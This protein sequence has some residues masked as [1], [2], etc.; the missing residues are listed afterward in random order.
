MT[1]TFFYSIA[2]L[3]QSNTIDDLLHNMSTIEYI[4]QKDRNVAEYCLQCAE[5]GNYPSA[6]Y[7]VNIYDKPKT[8]LKT[9][10][11]IVLHFKE[12]VD[13][14][15]RQA[16][17]RNVTTAINETSTSADLLTRLSKIIT[18]TENANDSEFSFDDC[19]PE[20]YGDVDKPL[21]SGLM[22]GIEELDKTTNG[23]QRGT[24]ASICGFTGH[25]KSTACNSAAYQNIV[26]G[27][28][29][30]IISI[31][32]PPDM[33]WK[34]FETR[35]M[36]EREL[37]VDVHNM[38][39]HT[40]D[41]SVGKQVV[42]YEP[43]FKRDVVPNLLVIDES[44]I[45]KK[46][47]TD[48]RKINKL[49]KAAE[50]K[51]GGLDMVIVDHVGQLELL[52]PETG[53]IILKQL[54]SAAKTFKN[55]NGEKIVMVWAVQCNREGNRRAIRREGQYDLQAIADLN[56]VERSS[57]YCVFLYTSDAMKITQE[58]KV[59]MLKNRLGVPIPVPFVTSFTPSVV[60]VGRKF[61]RANMSD[62]DFSFTEMG[63]EYEDIPP[64]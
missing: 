27:K 31:E 15:A 1:A 17:Q 34:Q 37:A 49:F 39:H 47:M 6:D 64:F 19:K 42:S 32:L 25:G 14:H 28:K 56:E 7:F 21:D 52:Y 30:L 62:V 20:L 51:L 26:S 11:E 59:S 53:N 13:F 22:T 10:A 50:R 46:I 29:V 43:D 3:K 41:D 4:N 63:G 60:M 18:D 8:V 23:F 61:D 38:E 36:F 58:T 16:V 57:S 40:L 48:Y 55:E 5:H 45:T 54:T 12:L 44:K 35:Y 33:V 2:G 24:V 9:E